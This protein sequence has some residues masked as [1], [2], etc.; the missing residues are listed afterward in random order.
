MTNIGLAIQK[1]LDINSLLLENGFN[2]SR[3]EE[4]NYGLQFSAQKA[5]YSGLIRIYQNKKGKVK[6]DLSQIDQTRSAVAL[7]TLIEDGKEAP[8]IEIANTQPSQS[9]SLAKPFLTI[10][11]P[12]IGSD[13]SGK[14][15]YFGSLTV[16]CVY[17][18]ED[19]AK[20]LVRIGVKDS[21][22]LKDTQIISIAKQIRRLCKGQFSVVEISPQ[23]Y[24]QMYAKLTQEKKTLNDM[25]AWA[26]AKVIETLL[27]KVDSN[28]A[29]VDKFCDDALLISNLQQEGKQLEIIQVHRAESYTAVAA[30]SILA[31]ERYVNSIKKLS[32]T[33]K[34]DIP[35]GAS[36]EVISVAKRLVANNGSEILKEVA[37]EHFKTTQSVL[38]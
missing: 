15:D 23:K 27:K 18:S 34:T 19:S 31:R 29:V 36:L 22:A 30:A 7:R 33:Y 11:P 6:V 14:G 28:L 1:Y 25:L 20:Q 32:K 4:I 35:K 5:D 26:H 8:S 37:K 21:K 24:N 13:E 16:A 3:Y 9:H 17:V 10:T 38:R 2:V 12:Y